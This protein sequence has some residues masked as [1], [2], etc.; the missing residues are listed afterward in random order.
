MYFANHNSVAGFSV[1]WFSH[2]WKIG[3]LFYWLL[4]KPIP[5]FSQL[6]QIPAK[7]N[8]YEVTYSSMHPGAIV[9][10]IQDNSWS[11]TLNWLFLGRNDDINKMLI[12]HFLNSACI[13]F[14]IW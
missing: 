3:I 12:S 9:N 13:F 6:K 10:Q 8:A 4:E 2:N 7:S 1:L 11:S 5:W 14:P